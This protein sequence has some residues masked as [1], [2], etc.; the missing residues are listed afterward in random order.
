MSYKQGQ[1][2]AAQIMDHIR[3]NLSAPDDEYIQNIAKQIHLAGINDLRCHF[4]WCSDGLDL[5]T[6]YYNACKE[7]FSKINDLLYEMQ[8]DK[9]E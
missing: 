8:K 1:K 9:K 4:M 7:T 5:D 3:D 2:F 6:P